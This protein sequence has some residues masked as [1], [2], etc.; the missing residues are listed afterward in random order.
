MKL[1]NLIGIVLLLIAVS[2]IIAMSSGKNV[3]SNPKTS[4]TLQENSYEPSIYGA[5]QISE[6]VYRNTMGHDKFYDVIDPKGTKKHIFWAYADC[7]IGNRIK[8]SVEAALDMN[9]LTD[10]YIHDGN[11]M[12]G[13][14]MVTC[15]NSSMKCAEPY[16]YDNCS[17]NI[18]IINPSKKEMV[19]IPNDDN[20]LIEK[21]LIL[22]KNW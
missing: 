11:L 7:P 18:C 21:K 3:Q 15:H 12:S 6:D 8:D 2:F 1:H 17:D 10:K 5:E 19:K 4:E 13:G 22:L 16:L 20:S 9:G 14:L